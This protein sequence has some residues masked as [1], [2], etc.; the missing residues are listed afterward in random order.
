[1]ST[2]AKIEIAL[3]TLV[4]LPLI[5][6]TI[7]YDGETYQPTEQVQEAAL[8]SEAEI[9]FGINTANYNVSREEVQQNE[10]FIGLLTGNGIPLEKASKMAER[11]KTVFDIRKIKSGRPYFVLEKKSDKKGWKDTMPGGVSYF[12]YQHSLVDYVVFDLENDSV[13]KGVKKVETEKKTTFGIVESSLSQTMEKS[14]ANPMLTFAL[15][16]VYAWAIDFYR[17]QKGDKFKVIYNESYVEG[18]SIGV[19]RIL[20]AVFTHKGEDYY[21]YYYDQ[22]SSGNGAY[23]DEKGESLKKAFLKAPLKFSHITSHYSMKRFHPVLKTFKA[24]LGTD[25]AAPTGTPIMTVGTGTILDAHYTA[26]NGNYVKVKHN[27]HIT[28]QYLHM[29]R[30]AAGIHPGVHVN[31]GQVI[32]YVGSTGLA[33]GPHVC[34]R[35]WQDG[36]QVDP[37]KIKALPADPISK[38]HK[39]DYD[40][41]VQT[42]NAELISVKEAVAMSEK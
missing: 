30:I 37:L 16:E 42:F 39:A 9:L 23:Y 41:L 17:L 21:A 5:Y 2:K 36:Q 32:G 28:T 8:K 7:F 22:D 19:D 27:Q 40:K 24:H 6:F 11:C 34:F 12:I 29:S 3:I 1:M 26:N 25:Y 31:Q 35:F 14:K 33:T 4:L 10:N 13:Y 38:K 15:S 18:K 20:A